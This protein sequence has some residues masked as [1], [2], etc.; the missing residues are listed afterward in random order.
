MAR[1]GDPFPLYYAKSRKLILVLAHAP[2]IPVLE[3]LAVRKN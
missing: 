3:V 1:Y 2:L